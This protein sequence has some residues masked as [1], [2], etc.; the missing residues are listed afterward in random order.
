MHESRPFVN[1]AVIG[2]HD[3]GGPLV[4]LRTLDGRANAI[5]LFDPRARRWEWEP[6]L[7]IAV[8]EIQN[9]KEALSRL[10]ASDVRVTAESEH[11]L[12]QM[13]L[14]EIIEEKAAAP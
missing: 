12:L 7:G 10:A 5:D 2:W 14:I 6:H 11:A 13:T 4:I 8:G 3:D 1:A 9:H